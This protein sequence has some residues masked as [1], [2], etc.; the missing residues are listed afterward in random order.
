MPDLFGRASTSAVSAFFEGLSAGTT[1]DNAIAYTWQNDGNVSLEREAALLDE[2]QA[3]GGLV[4]EGCAA[5]I[6]SRVK[7]GDY[8]DLAL[9]GTNVLGP[10][11]PD[12][13]LATILWVTSPGFLRLV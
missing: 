12:Q 10:I 5:H 13:H 8:D 1:D 4:P 7:A 9:N 11:P 6:R 3:Y 2:I